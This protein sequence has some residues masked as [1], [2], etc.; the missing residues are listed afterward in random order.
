MRLRIITD[1]D[2]PDGTRVVL[3]NTA[4]VEVTLIAHQTEDEDYDAAA[5]LDCELPELASFSVVGEISHVSS[6]DP[7]AAPTPSGGLPGSTS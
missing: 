7:G 4:G 1:H 3:S 6:Y 5:V 2:G